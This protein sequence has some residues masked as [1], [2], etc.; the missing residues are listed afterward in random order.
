VTHLGENLSQISRFG[1][2]VVLALVLPQYFVGFQHVSY[3]D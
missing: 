2:K 1:V 3:I